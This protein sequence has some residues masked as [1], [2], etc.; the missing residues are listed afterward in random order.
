[1]REGVVASNNYA[2]EEYHFESICDRMDSTV[3][4]TEQTT[5]RIMAAVEKSGELV[6]QIRNDP[7]VNQFNTLP[8]KITKNDTNVF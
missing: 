5:N 6:D 7:S 1:M 4:A 2:D 3:K 8:D